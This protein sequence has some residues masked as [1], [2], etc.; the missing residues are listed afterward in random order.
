ME[1]VYATLRSMGVTVKEVTMPSTKEVQTKDG[2]MVNKIL[3]LTLPFCQYYA[4][5]RALTLL[6]RRP[7]QKDV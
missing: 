1:H 6:R 5:Y 2:S 3:G 4:C 7:V